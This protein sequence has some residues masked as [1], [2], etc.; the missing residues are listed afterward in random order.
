M[1][2]CKVQLEKGRYDWS[3][4][5]VLLN[6]TRSITA[7]EIFEIYADLEGYKHPSIIR[8]DEYRPDLIVAK[9]NLKEIT[10]LELTVGFEM[11][12]DRSTINTLQTIIR[13]TR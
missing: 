2:G 6:R 9:K 13:T 10:L 5:S 12:L 3:H 11:N 7:T 4:N 1:G 8:G